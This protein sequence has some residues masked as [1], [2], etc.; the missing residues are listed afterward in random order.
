MI[1]GVKA[2][3]SWCRA[4]ARR[5]GVAA[6]TAAAL[7]TAGCTA[8]QRAQTADE[9]ETLDGTTVRVGQYITLGGLALVTPSKGPSW[10]RGANV[11]INAVVVN[12]G[13]Q[14]D[15]LTSI[16]SSAITSWGAY[17][18]LFQA[19]SADAG[20]SGGAP[21]SAPSPVD[22]PAQSRVA[23]SANSGSAA[24][25]RVLVVTGIKAPLYP[26][27]SIQLTFTF[28]NAGSVTAQVPVQLSSSPNTAVVPGPSA[29]GEEG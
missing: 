27:S 2:R 11:P 16:T 22:V 24:S 21:A 9:Q 4:T 6:L 10:A 1:A 13:R 15:K 17:P 28:A 3:G 19:M 26:G 18:S 14:A 20:T 8:G 5:T 29:T 7:L 25:T 23:F 12:N